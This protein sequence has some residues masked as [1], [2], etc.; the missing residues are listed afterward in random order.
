MDLSKT[1]LA[2][3]GYNVTNLGRT[4]E[5]LADPRY[6]PILEVYLKEASDVYHRVAG[7]RIDLVQRVRRRRE[8]NLRTYGQAVALI[9]A[10]E[11]AQLEMLRDVHGIDHRSAKASMG[12]S[13]GEITALA[14]GGV[15]D[16]RSALEVPIALAKPCAALAGDVSLAV[17]FSRE[18]AL[19]WDDIDRLC[20]EVNALGKGVLAVSAQLGPNTLLMMGQHDTLDRF[21]ELARE[22]LDARLI[23]RRNSH[24]WPPL[25]T[26]IV[27]QK[28]VSDQ[29]GTRMHALPVEFRLP[30]PPV[31]S[32]VTGGFDYT[33]MNFRKMLRRWV[34]HPQR[35]WDAVKTILSNS[36]THVLHV[37]PQ[38]NILPATLKRLAAN[39]TLQ[40]EASVG[41]RALAAVAR[42]PWLAAMLPEETALLRAPQLEQTTLE[43]WL[44]EH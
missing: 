24:R 43:D 2:F 11:M 23:V 1:I 16:W 26:P 35:L 9:V 20:L 22:R 7:R 37:G 39:V 32:L 42:R 13:L 38:P 41:K 10:V 21:Q 44:L 6:G 17:V 5:L 29:A 40:L 25:H 31:L 33:P 27:W 4:P 14:S 34:D 28:C 15:V 36:V 12:Y 19:A 8:T 3:R 18:T 30:E